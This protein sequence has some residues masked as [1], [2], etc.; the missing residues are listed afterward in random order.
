MFRQIVAAAL[1]AA[2]VGASAQ[3]GVIDTGFAAPVG[4]WIQ[5]FYAAD[6]E[7]ARADAMIV[8]PDQHIVVCSSVR[9]QNNPGTVRCFRLDADGFPDASTPF[10]QVILQG[11]SIVPHAI[12]LVRQSSGKLVVL[13]SGFDEGV[14]EL[15]LWRINPD[16]S[17]DTG[18]GV[19]G[20]KKVTFDLDDGKVYPADLM[21]Q[22]DD[23]LLIA[24][25]VGQLGFD[26]PTG[27]SAMATMRLLADGSVDMA[28]GT[29]GQ[30][31][32]T[33]LAE[34]A[35]ALPK[36]FV[37]RARL[38][39]DGGVLLAGGAAAEL[40]IVGGAGGGYVNSYKVGVAKLT[41][42]GTLDATFG[43]GG[44]L[45][46]DVGVPAPGLGAS[47]I[48]VA[49]DGSFYIATAQRFEPSGSLLVKFKSSGRVD[50]G[51]G[52]F[53]VVPVIVVEPGAG[54]QWPGQIRSMLVQPD[55]KLIAA[56]G[57][58]LSAR[59]HTIALRLLADG[60]PDAGFG[61]GIYGAG[62][63]GS[64]V[65][66]GGLGSENA[67]VAR[68]QGGRVLLGAQL[69]H[70]DVGN[71]WPMVYRLTSDAMFASGFE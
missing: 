9:Y 51:W 40:F 14:H 38:T 41:A 44:A 23:K 20:K 27:Q 7:D 5:S 64:F 59:S 12:G 16:G 56:G 50:F 69:V 6:A 53:G 43:D 49:A 11:V 31:V 3:E 63:F 17:I 47:T 71:Y 29:R 68:A 66:L 22:A 30:V 19:A 60:T 65:N 2:S 21:V 54:L 15:E 33:R 8:Q 61:V 18:F 37:A 39:A 1:L 35:N 57:A 70:Y 58:S 26:N 13:V 34:I 25:S 24:A 55:G 36:D 10:Q 28:Y 52:V 62:I 45:V 4:Y 32:V 67:Q 42:S 46:L 48:E